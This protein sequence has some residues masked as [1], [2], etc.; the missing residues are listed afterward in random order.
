MTI[1]YDGLIETFHWIWGLPYHVADGARSSIGCKSLQISLPFRTLK[2][3]VGRACSLMPVR[4]RAQWVSAPE[5]HTHF[6]LTA[7]TQLS[8]P[9]V[10]SAKVTTRL[11]Y[12]TRLGCVSVTFAPRAQEARSW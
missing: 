6:R 8:A 5:F 11:E 3:L 4:S 9:Y 1:F 7:I 12:E 10:A 2:K